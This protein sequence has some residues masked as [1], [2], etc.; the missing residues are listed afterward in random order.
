M[1][2]FSEE[3]YDNSSC[4]D[5]SSVGGLEQDQEEVQERKLSGVVR[6]VFVNYGMRSVMV[7]MDVDE[8][9]AQVRKVVEGKTGIPVDEQILTLSG[10]GRK[11][12]GNNSLRDMGYLG[13]TFCELSTV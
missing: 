4:C 7:R 1:N 8:S 5:A 2:Q 10:S 13:G 12:N 11:V 9:F 6:S 3:T